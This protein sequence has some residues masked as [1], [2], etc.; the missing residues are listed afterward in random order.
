MVGAPLKKA[1]QRLV[2]QLSGITLLMFAFGYS[3]V[4][5]YKVF[6][7]I[8]GTN[9]K[10]GRLAPAQAA[11]LVPDQTRE[12]TVEFVTNVHAG[13]PWDFRALNNSVRVHPGQITQVE[14]EVSNRATQA[15]V[16]QAVPSVA[17]NAA[18][19]YFSKTECFCFS[20]QPLAAGEK[21]AMP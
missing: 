21:K 17:P 10:T 9:G 8:T 5:L 12:I 19:R 11:L 6:C 7:E 15:L 20:Q 2:V 13:L 1:N 14:F 4:P 3:L 16:G 18:A